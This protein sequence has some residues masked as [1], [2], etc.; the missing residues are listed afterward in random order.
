MRKGPL[1]NAGVKFP[2]D[3]VLDDRFSLCLPFLVCPPDGLAT[4]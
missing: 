4:F 1:G 2:L 3:R